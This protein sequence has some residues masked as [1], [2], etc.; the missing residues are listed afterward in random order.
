MNKKLLKYQLKDWLPL[1]G[2][3]F[4]IF[5]VVILSNTF[6]YKIIDRYS[7]LPPEEAKY[8]IN[9]FPRIGIYNTPFLIVCAA[10]PLFALDYRFKHTQADTFYQLPFKEKE[11]KRTRLVLGLTIILVLFTF[12]YWIS[13]LIFGIRYNN[14]LLV[15][16]VDKT[17]EWHLIYSLPL[18]L[19]LII[20]GSALYFTSAFLVSLGNNTLDSII[21]VLCGQFILGLIIG[22]A[23]LFT[24]DIY[25]CITGNDFKDINLMVYG[26][27]GIH[28]G[29]NI[30]YIFYSLING[31]ELSG[32]KDF[33]PSIILLI[34]SLV[35]GGAA[36][37][38]M[39]IAK[40]PS[41]E[42]AGSIK[43]RY[44]WIKW[45]YYVSFIIITYYTIKF[46]YY[47]PSYTVIIWLTIVYI[48]Y[49]LI[50][51]ISNRSFK[52]TKQDIIAFIVNTVFLI[53]VIVI[54][55]L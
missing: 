23:Y 40:E 26:L 45:L 39:F 54:L 52:P 12:F 21:Y 27:S 34:V 33:I 16:N 8:Q 22:S 13:I 24:N 3:I 25:H 32:L 35:F 9:Q 55:K 48:G 42:Y 7:Y 15:E 38:Y 14:A 28:V 2:V 29:D 36:F 10:M 53:A 5:A 18:Y 4:I 20:E 30:H 43:K 6:N 17:N 49:Y 31:M 37:A 50:I 1:I 47:S 46:N 19:T 41:G 11:L 44:R 51:S